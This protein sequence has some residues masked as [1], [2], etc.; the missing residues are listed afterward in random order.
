MPVTLPNRGSYL[1][2]HIVNFVSLSYES[3]IIV[4]RVNN[5]I[6]I[7]FGNLLISSKFY[8]QAVDYDAANNG[9]VIYKITSEDGVGV[10]GGFLFHVDYISGDL[11]LN[12]S[13]PSLNSSFGPHRVVIQV[14]NE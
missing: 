10:S 14:G 6:P 8:C 13:N 11:R 12:L 5:L 9:S 2:C 3:V 7:S 4:S 1:K